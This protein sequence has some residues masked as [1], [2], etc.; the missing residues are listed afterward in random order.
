VKGQP[1]AVTVGGTVRDT[2]GTSVDAAASGATFLGHRNP[3]LLRLTEV[4]PQ[5][6]NDRDLVELLVLQ[7][8]ATVGMTLVQDSTGVL[9][10]FPDAWVVAGDL[11]VV[12]LNPVPGGLLDGPGSETVAKDQYPSV[13]HAWNYDGA[14]D[15]HGGSSGVSF[16]NQVL[17]IADPTGATQDGAAFTAQWASGPPASFPAALQRLQADGQW[18]PADCGGV[19]CTYASTPSATDPTISASWD[20]VTFDRSITVRRVDPWKDGDRASDWAVGPSSVGAL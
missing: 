6:G 20:G 8:G 14:W 5:I 19:A 12:H 17:R 16:S 15:F 18:L 11:I 2:V 7:E 13:T 3:A 9:A 1:Y 4:A 10:T